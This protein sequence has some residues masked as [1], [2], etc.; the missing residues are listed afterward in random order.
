[1]EWH[2]V[3]RPKLNK[4]ELQKRDKKTVV[5]RGTLMSELS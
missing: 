5:A 3:L 1:M 2:V 4:K